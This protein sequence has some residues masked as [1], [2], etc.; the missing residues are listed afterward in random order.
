MTELE[1][2]LA[3]PTGA[4]LRD[5]LQEKLLGTEERLRR[6]IAEGVPRNQFAS[7]QQAAEAVAAARDVL[8]QWQVGIEPPQSAP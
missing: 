1:E 3:L 7:W 5:R 8:G 4:M 2:Q 6:Q